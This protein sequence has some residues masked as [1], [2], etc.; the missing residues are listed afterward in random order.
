MCG[1]FSSV[2]IL[3]P[4]I[5]VLALSQYEIQLRSENANSA[6]VSSRLQHLL[7]RLVRKRYHFPLGNRDPRRRGRRQKGVPRNARSKF[8]GF[9]RRPE[10]ASLREGGGPRSGGRSAE[11]QR[12]LLRFGKIQKEYSFR[13]GYALPPGRGSRVA[14]KSNTN[15][16]RANRAGIT[17]RK[18]RAARL[19]SCASLQIYLRQPLYARAFG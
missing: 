1:R 17:S 11:R 13:Q 9:P 7:A 12:D 15:D 10:N 14:P 19:A 2:L 4:P 8:W 5:G 18:R 6:L 16:A 3:F